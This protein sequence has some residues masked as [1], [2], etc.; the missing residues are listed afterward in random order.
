L[1][2]SWCTDDQELLNYVCV[3]VSIKLP[4]DL[5]A[6][7][8]RCAAL[9]RGS[10]QRDG[11]RII[12]MICRIM[13]TIFIWGGLDWELCSSHAAYSSPILGEQSPLRRADSEFDF[14][15]ILQAGWCRNLP[16]FGT[17][18]SSETEQL[19]RHCIASRL[20]HCCSTQHMRR[21]QCDCQKCVYRGSKNFTSLRN[22]SAPDCPY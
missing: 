22:T 10:R 11:R 4:G 18:S 15:P 14:P 12:V 20:V 5:P 1:R 2:Y 17:G 21:G 16:F 9:N 19:R 8:F 6:L 3:C 13:F 7:R